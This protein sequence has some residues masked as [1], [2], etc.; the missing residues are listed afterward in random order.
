MDLEEKQYFSIENGEIS[1]WKQN[2][3]DSGA[4]N[5]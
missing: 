5:S 2:A 3:K 4:N 1:S